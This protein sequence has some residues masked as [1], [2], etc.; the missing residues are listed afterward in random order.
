MIGSRTMKCALAVAALAVATAC[1]PSPDQITATYFSPNAFSGMNCGQL[2]TERAAIAQRLP[3]LV[4]RQ[5]RAASQD[6]AMVTGAV[7]LLP[8]AGLFAAGGEDHSAE[9]ASLR[10][11][12]DAVAAAIRAS[13]C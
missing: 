12:A 13:G 10:G 11:Q 4:A 6:A 8:I 7:L 3:D 1:A 2:L 5:D 9:I